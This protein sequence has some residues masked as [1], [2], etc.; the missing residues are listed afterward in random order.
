[1]EKIPDIYYK[2]DWRELY[3]SKDNGIPEEYKL[4]SEF[5]IIIYPYI[6]TL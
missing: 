5:G 1:M 6:K 2:K 4:E 3:A